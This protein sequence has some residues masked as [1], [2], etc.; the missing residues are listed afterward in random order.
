MFEKIL[1]KITKEDS[2]LVK[3]IGKDFNEVTDLMLEEFAR[4]SIDGFCCHDMARFLNAGFVK[5]DYNSKIVD[6]VTYYGPACQHSWVE[7]R[8]KTR[9]PFDKYI[10]NLIFHPYASIFGAEPSRNVLPYIE[11]RHMFKKQK[12]EYRVH[13]GLDEVI[14]RIF[15]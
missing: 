12:I 7:V 1:R 14:E 2:I 13:K 5:K 11:N 15:V 10:L 4:N 6:G 8:G 3:K 9:N